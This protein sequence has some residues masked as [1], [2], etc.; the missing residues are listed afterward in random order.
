[1]SGCACAGLGVARI[2]LVFS[3]K[4]TLRADIVWALG[5]EPFA[6]M[7]RRGTNE[8]RAVATIVLCNLSKEIAKNVASVMLALGCFPLVS[9][10]MVCDSMGRQA[11]W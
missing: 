1:M 5:V 6:A 8:E 4:K 3:M 11:S 2:L 10:V 9:T 7:L